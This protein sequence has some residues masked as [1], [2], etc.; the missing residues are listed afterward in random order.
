MVDEHNSPYKSYSSFSGNPY[1]VDLETLYDK[2]LLTNSELEGAK[3]NSPWLCEYERLQKERFEL[4]KK[5]S[6]RT[7]DKKKISKFIKDNP[8]IASFCEFMALKHENHD[9][10]WLDWENKKCNK[11]S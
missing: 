5:A 8:R 1:F 10:E 9:K 4:L 3:Q 2:G 6:S 11:D 7:S